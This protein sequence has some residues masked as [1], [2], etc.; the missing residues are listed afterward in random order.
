M[1]KKLPRVTVKCGCCGKEMQVIQSR[2][3]IGRGKYC[4]RSC[5][6]K[7]TSTKHGYTTHNTLS[8]TYGTWSMM[9]QRC[10]N[11][12]ATKY[13]RYGAVGIDV[14]D[15]WLKFDAFLRDMGDRPKD[16]TLDRL[17]NEKGYF[18]TNC[19]WATIA[20]QSQNKRPRFSVLPRTQ[21]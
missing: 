3:D 8:P 9:V 11:P 18:P 2:L 12:K 6:N 4:S 7:A 17:D 1:N 10:R 19:R 14:C 13:P 16:K 5:G 20:E 21:K 15:E